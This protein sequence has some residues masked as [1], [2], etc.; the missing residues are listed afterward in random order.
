MINLKHNLAYEL[1]KLRFKFNILFSF[2]SY[3][4]PDFITT[5]WEIYNWCFEGHHKDSPWQSRLALQVTTYI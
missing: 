3:H 4:E 1:N 5:F 2:K